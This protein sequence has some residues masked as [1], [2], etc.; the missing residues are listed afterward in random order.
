MNRVSLKFRIPSRLNDGMKQLADLPLNIVAKCVEDGAEL[1]AKDASALLNELGDGTE[2]E[3]SYDPR[4]GDL[5]QHLSALTARTS[6]PVDEL[7]P[8]IFAA[9][10]AVDEPKFIAILA[11]RA[12]HATMGVGPTTGKGSSDAN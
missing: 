5:A 9:G 3:M 6:R 7:L 2:V 11:K 10:F 12:V 1:L 8:S 4:F